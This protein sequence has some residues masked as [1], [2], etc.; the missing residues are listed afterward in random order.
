MKQNVKYVQDGIVI[1]F[2]CSD[3][4]A[5]HA[6]LMQSIAASMCAHAL[7]PDPQPLVD[8]LRVILPDE[9]TLER[10]IKTQ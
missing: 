7:Q 10:G 4:A 6:A 1:H 8:L 2:P 3:P 9:Q 5:M